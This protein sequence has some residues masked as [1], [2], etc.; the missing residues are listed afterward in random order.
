MSPFADD[1][2]TYTETRTRTSAAY[3]KFTPDYKV[4][5]RILNPNA[6][7]AWKHWIQEANSGKG[8]MATCPNI[9]AQT[10]VCPIE[11]AAK[12]T[13]KDDP[14]YEAKVSAG[15]ARKRFM[16][17]VL[18]RTPYTVCPSCNT[19]TPGK[20]C[21][22]C[23]ASLKD[24]D[25]VPLNKIK[26]L[27]GGPRLFAETLNAIDQLQK[28]EFGASI[29]DY[30]ITFV[31]QGVG[32]EKKINA[33]PQEVKFDADKNII[34]LPKDALT[35]KETGEPQKLFDLDLLAEPSSSEEIELMLKGA[36]MQE[37]NLSRGIA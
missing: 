14:D 23:Q 27:E 34:P 31:T 17:N 11:R 16:V 10:N 29:T 9:T 25:F 4:V 5:L 12:A 24:S 8:M 33:I 20:I 6:K 36:N 19:E 37:I 18:D 15:R 30:D 13:P 35:D 1:A 26:I 3:V 2:R 7:R 21:S 28:E 32:R 22:A